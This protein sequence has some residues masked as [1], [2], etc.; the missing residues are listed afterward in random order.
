MTEEAS[1]L[2]G[3]VSISPPCEESHGG[4]KEDQA[5]LTEDPS[6]Q[7]MKVVNE[8]V[9]VKADENPRNSES[10]V[11]FRSGWSSNP[12][13]PKGQMFVPVMEPRETDFQRRRREEKEEERSELS[14]G[15]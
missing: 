1:L 12:K 11:K 3:T 4:P 8:S 2:D 15:K 9:K 7:T 6:T 5:E 14:S 10:G 13:V